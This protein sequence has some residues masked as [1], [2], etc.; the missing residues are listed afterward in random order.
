MAPMNNLG[1]IIVGLNT[2]AYLLSWLQSEFTYAKNFTFSSMAFSRGYFWNI[3]TCHFGHASFFTYILDSIIVGLFCQNLSMALGP[4]MIGR[5]ILASLAGGS[6]I[7][8][9]QH[10]MGGSQMR[11]FCGNDAILRGLIWTLIFTNPSAKLMLFPLPIEFPAY[12][13]GIVMLLLDLYSVNTGAFGGTM[14]AYAIVN[15][16]L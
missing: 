16:F 6:S 8:L 15:N 7:L 14:A 1:L 12:G 11:P 13:I 5:I 2:A 9:L 10:V 4:T 3:F